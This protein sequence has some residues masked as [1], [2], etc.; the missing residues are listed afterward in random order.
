MCP[1]ILDTNFS[2]IKFVHRPRVSA[3][4][5]PALLTLAVTKRDHSGK[6]IN[7]TN[8]DHKLFI[9]M[10]SFHPL[11]CITKLTHPGP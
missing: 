8:L 5:W 2:N 11:I 7:H 10:V 6:K 3:K 1:V 9:W 4:A